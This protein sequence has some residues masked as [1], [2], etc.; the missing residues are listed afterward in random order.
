MLPARAILV[1]AAA[2]LGAQISAARAADPAVELTAAEA[3]APEENVYYRWIDERGQVQY[4]DFEPIGIPAER[5]VLEPE[6]AS[7]DEALLAPAG[8]E[9]RPDPFH[10]QDGQILPIEHVGP[11][12]DARRQLAV[13]YSGLPVYADAAGRFQTAWRG[14]PYRG[15]RRYLADEE[16]D[17]AIAAARAGVLEHC[18][19]PA[20]FE[21]EVRAFRTQV[22]DGGR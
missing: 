10:D 5:Q 4:T 18:S 19:D 20:A 16:R 9:F 17:V 15:E 3:P 2:L 11:C 14:D 22:Q 21:A 13:L 6:S 8:H 7:G 1:L 12:A